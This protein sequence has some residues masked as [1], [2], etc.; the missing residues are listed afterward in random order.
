MQQPS[1]ASADSAANNNGVSSHKTQ[2]A[3]SVRFARAAR[4]LLAFES[5]Q[6]A[7]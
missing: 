7:H 3:R 2:A 1:A 4:T 5:A 6:T